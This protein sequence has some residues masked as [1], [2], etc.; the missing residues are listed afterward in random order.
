MSLSTRMPRCKPPPPPPPPPVHSSSC[1]PSSSSSSS[2]WFSSAY[3]SIRLDWLGLF[4]FSFLKN[5]HKK[6]EE[7]VGSKRSKEKEAEVVGARWI[8]RCR[9]ILKWI[10]MS[11]RVF[12]GVLGLLLLLF[13][14]TSRLE[15]YI[16]FLLLLYLWD[17]SKSYFQHWYSGGR[18]CCEGRQPTS[19]LTP[20]DLALI[21]IVGFT[22]ARLDQ[23]TAEAERLQRHAL[24]IESNQTVFRPHFSSAATK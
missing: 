15:R 24:W 19:C 13:W 5:K 7:E 20:V 3:F 12:R 1:R 4:F 8:D 22:L 14:P 2:L 11:L 21:S 17:W 9:W 10:G 18:E 23:W 6:R 16:S